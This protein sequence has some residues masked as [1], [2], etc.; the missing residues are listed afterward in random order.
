LKGRAHAQFV[1]KKRIPKKNVSRKDSRGW[2]E[3]ETG[4][5]PRVLF[6]MQLGR[7]RDAG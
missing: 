2:G 1:Q 7:Q 6:H 3:R 4:E 5:P